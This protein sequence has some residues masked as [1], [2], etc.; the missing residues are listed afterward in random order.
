MKFFTF[1]GDHGLIWIIIGLTFILSE[2]KG[3][4]EFFKSRF[5]INTNKFFMYGILLLMSLIISFLLSDIILKNIFQR[6]RP[7]VDYQFDLI[8]NPPGGY[9]MPSGHSATS[10]ASAFIIYKANKKWGIIAILIAIMIAFSRLYLTVHYPTDVIVGAVI[11]CLCS[12][13]IY[14]TGEK[15]FNKKFLKYKN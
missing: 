6:P 10:F 15:L 14:L 13:I 12:Y 4:K 8:I 1:L 7:F 2:S 9:S 5:N 3:G 11:G